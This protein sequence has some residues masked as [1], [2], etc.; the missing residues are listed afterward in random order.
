MAIERRPTG[1]PQQLTIRWALLFSLVITVS[2]LSGCDQV[3]SVLHRTPLPDLGPRLANSV[4]LTFD[5][6]FTN[7]TMQY[8][9]GCNSPHALNVGEE[10]ESL[11]IDA[12]S[13]NFRAVTVVDVGVSS[14]QIPSSGIDP[15]AV[16]R[17]TAS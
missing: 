1:F 9:D 5:P 4:K 15:L 12:I 6:S 14:P 10:I 16:V 13:K 2:E 3:T 17:S 11:M 7:L 8:I